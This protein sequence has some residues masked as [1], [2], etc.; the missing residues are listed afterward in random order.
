[1]TLCSKGPLTCFR[2]SP[3]ILTA[4]K[5]CVTQIAKLLRLRSGPVLYLVRLASTLRG[6][7]AL[8]RSNPVCQI[9]VPSWPRHGHMSAKSETNKSE[10]AK[11]F[12][13]VSEVYSEIFNIPAVPPRPIGGRMDLD[14]CRSNAGRK[15]MLLKC[16][17]LVRSRL[18]NHLVRFRKII[19]LLVKIT[20]FSI[21]SYVSDITHVTL[22]KSHKLH[23]LLKLT[24]LLSLQKGKSTVW[25]I[26]PPP[27]SDFPCF[28]FCCTR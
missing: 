1:M 24:Y 9:C 23:H 11:M 8:R 28:L 25:P 3:P 19:I 27:D 22:C 4:S 15:L 2:R 21:E 6:L 26:R 14:Q 16:C 20:T 7:I 10:L 17:G 5:T 18:Q 12:H 13:L